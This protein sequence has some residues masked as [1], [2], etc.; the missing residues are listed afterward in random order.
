MAA[1]QQPVPT[2][3]NPGQP[4]QQAFQ[5]VSLYVGDLDPDVTEALLFEVFNAVGPVASIRVCRDTVTRRSLGYGYVNFH[6]TADAERALDTMN[7]TSIRGRPCRIMWCQRDP[8]LR[9]TG[10][11]NVFVKNLDSSIDNN[12]LYERFSLFGNILSCKVVVD[13]EDKS[14]GYGFVHYETVEAAEAAIS[15]MNGS[16]IHEKPVFVGHFLRR[17]E[18]ADSSKWTNVYVKNV[19]LTVD[20]AGFRALFAEFGEITSSV[21]QTTS[22]GV[23][24]GFGFVNFKEHDSARAASDALNGK[25]LGEDLKPLTEEQLA[26][27]AAEEEKE[28]GKQAAPKPLYVGRAQKKSE[29][30][31]E[32]SAKF[33]QL[34]LERMRKYEGVNLYVKNLDESVDDARLKQEFARFGS[35]TSARIMRDEAGVSKG[36]GFVCFSTPEEATAV[37]TEMNGKL[38]G[39]KP[40]YV[41]LAQRKEAR[42]AA[43]EAAQSQRGGAPSGAVPRGAQ[44]MFGGPMMYQQQMVGGP[45]QQMVFHGQQGMPGQHMPFYQQQQQQMHYQQQHMGG[46]RGRGRGRNHPRHNN[47]AA[48]AQALAHA[49]AQAQQ[50]VQF[51]ATARNMQQQSQQQPAAAPAPAAQS[52]QQLVQQLTGLEPLTPSTLAAA[53]PEMQKN[54]IGERLYPLIAQLQPDLAGK[55]TGMLLEMDNTELL[56]LLE[57]PEAMQAKITEAM[58]VLDAHTE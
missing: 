31:K 57:S 10:A 26:A 11:G 41:N 14:L 22:E 8:S 19:P 5:S 58:L 53:S 56:L 25:T 7:Y 39:G 43:L 52:Q 37:I 36:F 29:R 34:K 55:I 47:H 24:K 28:E 6:N 2:S 38:L 9:K 3:A 30:Q 42:R 45:P 35:I 27:A 4:G 48:Q 20:A 13:K 23:S 18:R 32:L 12:L 44:Q 16:E 33:E 17:S 54:M 49:Q 21:L 46:G 40:L 51:T 50:Q 15:G 1:T